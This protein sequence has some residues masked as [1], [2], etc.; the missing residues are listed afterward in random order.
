MPSV[1]LWDVMDTLVRD[2]FF[3]HMAGF[4]GL[5]FDE[6]LRRK[7]PTTWRRFELGEVDEQALFG[8]FFA[9]GT[10]IDG[11]AFKRC[12]RDAY[13][14][15]E[16]IEP[17]LAELRASGV[18]MYALS[19]YPVWYRLIDERLRL[20]SYVDLRFISCET[21]VRKPAPEA[22]LGAC[23]A[24]CLPPAECLFVDDRAENCLAAAKLGLAALQFTGDVPAL[25]AA[26]LELGLLR[27]NR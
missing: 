13:A 21:G 12:V 8:R 2:P 20:S 17:L 22:Y 9:D 5:S 3:T 23:R 11:P 15:I 24:L 19:N 16:G 18:A 26:L 7:H 25:R 4:F 10:P 1:I 27:A 14:W 6:L